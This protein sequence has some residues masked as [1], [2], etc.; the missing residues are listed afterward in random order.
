MAIDLDEYRREADRFLAALEEEYYLHHA[1][2]KDI[3]EVAPIYER[4]AELGTLEAC[5]ELE[6]AGSPELWRFACEQY[7]GRLTAEHAERIAGLEASLEAEIDGQPL[8]YRLLPVETANEPDRDRRRRLDE[9]RVDLVNELNPIYQEAFEQTQ[10]G[11][12]ELGAAD[13]CD[14]YERFGYGLAGLAEPLP[15]FLVETEEL[16]VGV[17]DRLFRDRLQIPLAEAERFDLLRLFRADRW[18]ASFPADRMVPALE[19]TLEAWGVRLGEQANLTVD[20]ERRPLK[21][22]RAFCSPIDVPGRIVLCIQPIGGVDDWRALFHEAGHAEHFAHTS[23]RLPLE[24][25]RLGDNT[26]TEAW[27]FLLEDLVSDRSWLSRRLDLGGAR[28]LEAEWAAIRLLRG[29]GLAGAILY[30]LELWRGAEG[31]PER[32]AELLAEATKIAPPPADYLRSVDAAFYATR[33]LRALA[34]KA[35]ILAFLRQEFGRDWFASRRAGSL[36][37]ELWHEGQGLDGDQLAREVTGTGLELAALAEEAREA[38][39]A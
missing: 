12:R 1:G 7:L 19:A 32:Y 31:M 17:L 28:E 20:V 38:L 35:Q 2:L 13:Y 14:L 4:Y 6:V 10:E 21:D 5:R 37:C 26:V 33:Y 30:Q 23:P 11:A 34:L 39:N 29:R 25:R 16:Y 18:D 15:S 36:L 9:A 8:G 3:L 24:A 22:S 27:A